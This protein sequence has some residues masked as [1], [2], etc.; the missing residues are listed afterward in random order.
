MEYLLIIAGIIL[1]FASA[2]FFGA[3]Y[4]PTLA[5]TKETA[6]D[7]LDLKPGQTMLDLGSGDGT[8]LLAAARRG[9]RAVGI[10]LNPFLVIYSLFKTRKYRRQ[11]KVKWGNIWTSKWP[12][13]DAIYVFMI[14]RFMEKLD[15]KLTQNPRKNIKVVSNSFK[16][17]TKKPIKQDFG[18]YLY[19]Y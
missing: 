14:D 10:E 11:V 2:V 4:L 6:L 1:V 15:K 16:I 9:W 12:E 3:P 13:H 5:K 7:L 18:L 17:A 8:M 19:K